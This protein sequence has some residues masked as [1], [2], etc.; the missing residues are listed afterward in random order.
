MWFDDEKEGPGKFIYL[1]KR[2]C[3]TG[4]WSRGQPRCGTIEN[5]TSIP[6]YPGCKYD[7]PP[8]G[9]ENPQKVLDI[10]REILHGDRSRRLV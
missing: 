10:E 6:G 5:L 3:Y 2:Q 1:T 4:E 7:M 8:I 9:L